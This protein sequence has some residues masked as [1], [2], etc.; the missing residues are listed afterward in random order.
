MLEESQ[1]PFSMAAE[2][3][4]MTGLAP[5][6]TEERNRYLRQIA[7]LHRN[8]GHSPVEHLVKALQAR[9]SDPRL[10]E[11]ARSYQCPTCQEAKRMVPRPQVSLE[12]LPP[13]WKVVQADNAFWNH[14]TDGKKYQFTLMI[15]EGCRFRVGRVVE[16]GRGK[17]I[18]GQDLINVFQE[19]WK[20]VFGLP[21]RLRVDPAGAWRSG[22]VA[23][24]MSSQ[25]IELDT[26]PAEAHWQISHVERAI[27]C[28]KHIMTKLAMEDPEITAQE[29]L[30]EAL[31][32]ENEREIVRGYSPAQHALGRSPDS[33]GRFHPSGMKEIP[34]GL[35][36]N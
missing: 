36:E 2:D 7:G 25:N 22:Q 8:S 13:K 19:L 11:L 34:P 5:L 20:P 18:N 33:A 12:P 6:N 32:T 21:D 35:C 16:T 3:D 14:P 26:I 30:A 4:P 9:G 27:K 10:L 28:T 31:R 24:Y 23:D 17:G 15:D 1:H 29:A